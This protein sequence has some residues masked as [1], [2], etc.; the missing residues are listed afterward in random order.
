MKEKLLMKRNN[1]RLNVPTG[2]KRC[3]WRQGDGSRSRADVRR[4]AD[5][6]RGFILPFFMGVAQGLC[7]EHDK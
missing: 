6:A 4:L 1:K 3:E 7:T 2:S 5:L